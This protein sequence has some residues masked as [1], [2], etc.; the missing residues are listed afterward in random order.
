MARSIPRSASTSNISTFSARASC[1]SRIFDVVVASNLF[2]DIL[3]DLGPACTG[4]IGLAPSANLNPER[5]FPSL[6]EPVHGSAPDIY[7]EQHRQPDRHDLVRRAD[8]RFPWLCEAD[9]PRPPVVY[10]LGAKD[11][12]WSSTAFNIRISDFGTSAGFCLSFRFDVG[13]A[14]HL[15]P[16]GGSRRRRRK[17]KKKRKKLGFPPQRVLGVD[18]GAGHARRVSWSA[19][20]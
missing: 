15:G 14:D 8:A 17:N 19:R 10:R 16:L 9:T 3:S 2:G 5:K 12:N 18:R 7:G 20:G 11:P 6:F 13:R 4:T 1:C